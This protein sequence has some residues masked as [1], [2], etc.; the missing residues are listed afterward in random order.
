MGTSAGKGRWDGLLSEFIFGISRSSAYSLAIAL[1][2]MCLCLVVYLQLSKPKN[3]SA[4]ASYLATHSGDDDMF[5]TAEI[6]NRRFRDSAKIPVYLLG[7]SSMR[8]SVLEDLLERQ[9]SRVNPAF[10]TVNLRS[11]GQ[12]LVQTLGIVDNLPESE[13]GGFVVVGISPARFMMTQQAISY[14]INGTRLGFISDETDNFL[15]SIGE[16]PSRKYGIYGIDNFKFLLPR[17]GKLVVNWNKEPVKHVIHMST[18]KK[19]VSDSRMRN[20]GQVYLN[21]ITLPYE[22]YHPT[23]AMGK[24]IILRILELTK[25]KKL[26][27]VLVESPVNPTFIEEKIGSEFMTKYYAAVKLFS[28]QNNIEYYNARELVKIDET[29][30]RDIVHLQS[31]DSIKLFTSSLTEAL[32]KIDEKY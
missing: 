26:T 19:R 9:L 28:E 6:L 14:A 5:I 11:G 22:N 27:L 4:I 32:V 24:D 30:F 17:F 16:K 31:L 23:A 10:E 25:K 1:L 20:L 2:T 15:L 3:V 21:K 13:S 8:E 29:D 18:V 12:F 7:D